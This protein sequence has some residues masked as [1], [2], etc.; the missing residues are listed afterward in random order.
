[1]QNKYVLAI[2]LNVMKVK[3]EKFRYIYFVYLTNDFQYTG[4]LNI[5]LFLLQPVQSG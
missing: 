5:V 1:M 2:S 4:Q 3:K